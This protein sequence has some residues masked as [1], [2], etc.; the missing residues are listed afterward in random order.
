MYLVS[1]NIIC[2]FD[3]DSNC[4]P[5][6]GTKEQ[7]MFHPTNLWKPRCTTQKYCILHGAAELLRRQAPTLWICEHLD[8]RIDR[9]SGKT[10]R[11]TPTPA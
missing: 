2:L 6:N 10:Y 3:F 11:T 8:T 1:M 4:E 9:G 7:E 5:L